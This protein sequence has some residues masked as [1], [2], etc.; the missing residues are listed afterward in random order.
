MALSRAGERVGQGRGTLRRS[1]VPNFR[2]SS[3]NV[4]TKPTDFYP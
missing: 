1:S 4:S 3:P 2:D